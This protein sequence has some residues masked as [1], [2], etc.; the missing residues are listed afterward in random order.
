MAFTIIKRQGILIPVEMDN[1]VTLPCSRKIERSRGG[2]GGGGWGVKNQ[3]LVSISKEI[4][5]FALL[6]APRVHNYYRASTR[7]PEYRNTQ[8]NQDFKRLKQ[9][10]L[11]PQLFRKICK[12]QGTLD[13]TLFALR[14]SHQLSQCIDPLDK[15]LDAL[16]INWNQIYSQVFPQFALIGKVLWKL[17]QN[18]FSIIIITPTQ[19]IQSCF[20]G[21]LCIS[22]KALLL[23]PEKENL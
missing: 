15:G 3:K 11:K 14:V 7:V 4:Q 5:D 6:S 1:M 20:P 13:I 21:L 23:V 16:K 8:G 22:V 9:W 12:D 19:Q 18:Q 2:T 17:S 10:K